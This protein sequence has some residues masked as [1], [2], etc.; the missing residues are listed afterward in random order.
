MTELIIY[1]TTATDIGITE[2]AG[3]LPD[4]VAEGLGAAAGRG[5]H[6]EEQRQGG[7]E[8]LMLKDV[9]ISLSREWSYGTSCAS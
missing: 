4:W 7:A 2:G 5:H 6:E 1:K 9:N 3:V 8:Q